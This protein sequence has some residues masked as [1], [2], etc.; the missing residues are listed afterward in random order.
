[1]SRLAVTPAM[2]TPTNTPARHAGSRLC[3]KYIGTSE[4]P[5]HASA[6]RQHLSVPSRLIRRYQRYIEGMALTNTAA[7]RNVALLSGS[8]SAYLM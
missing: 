7:E 6:M 8:C 3:T 5:S 4:S 2:P 1:M